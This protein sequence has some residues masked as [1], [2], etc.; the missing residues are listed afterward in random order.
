[1]TTI[2]NVIRDPKL[3]WMLTRVVWMILET[4]R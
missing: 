4:T 1:M 3:A 2:L